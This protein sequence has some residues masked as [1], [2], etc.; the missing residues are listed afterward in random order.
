[1][2]TDDCDSHDSDTRTNND[3]SSSYW[4][5]IPDPPPTPNKE[6][7]KLATVKANVASATGGL[8]ALAGSRSHHRQERKRQSFAFRDVTNNHPCTILKCDASNHY[9]ATLTKNS[10]SSLS[11]LREDTRLCSNGV[12]DENSS[13]SEQN[14]TKRLRR[15]TMLLPSD[16][17]DAML[18]MT[19]THTAWD[20]NNQNENNATSNSNS[21]KCTSRNSMVQLVRKYY[22][23][24]KENKR[25]IAKEIESLAGYPMPGYATNTQYTRSKEEFILKVQP[26]VQALEDRK[27]L[28][29]LEA[30]E[31]TRCRVMKVGKEG[32]SYYDVSTGELVEA[33]EYELRYAAMLDEKLRKR[34]EMA[35][36][37][38]CDKNEGRGVTGFCHFDTIHDVESTSRDNGVCDSIHG[39]G[40]SVNEL[41]WNGAIDHSNMDLGEGVSM[42]ESIM[43]INESRVLS[44]MMRGTPSPSE[45]ES[46]S[47]NT[48]S[49]TAT[50]S[51]DGAESEKNQHE[52]TDIGSSPHHPAAL[53]DMPPTNDPRV[54]AA[55]TR[56]W[57]AI[58]RALAAYSKE[59]IEI[60]GGGD[61]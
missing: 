13:T 40:C 1:M 21:I 8:A 17:Q 39:K 46:S 38:G 49:L 3:Y 57:L 19:V 41:N 14:K 52:F 26:I 43:S 23:Q 56:L 58:D 54:L 7:K 31:F 37:D 50:E 28:D 33:K 44:A 24:P 30:E 5:C 60:Q 61:N 35:S 12:G 29:V 6:S 53:L 20:I 45:E 16:K 55:R 11:I 59:I 34:K 15:Q 10:A 18:P 48:T 4:K 32:F 51:R 22:S 9:A 47:N 36:D 27:Q 2:G 42:E 25:I